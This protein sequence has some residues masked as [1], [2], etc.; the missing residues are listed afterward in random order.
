MKRSLTTLVA[1]ALTLALPAVGLSADPLPAD[2]VADEIAGPAVRF[3]NA[4]LADDLSTSWKLL[5]TGSRQQ[6][7]A[8][9]WDHAFR[10]RPTVRKPSTN[11][12][13]KAFANS[14]EPPE[15]RGVLLRPGEAL[16]EVGGTV[17]IT[18][19]LVLV[20]EGNAW[21]VDIEAS[22]ELNARG[23]AQSFLEAVRA[24]AG[25]TA[26]PSVRTPPASLPILK[27]L[28]A[29][30]VK[31]YR[32]LD[33]EIDGD[34]AS[35]TLAADIPVNLV[36]RTVRLGPGWMVDL[37]R[38]ALATD[39]TDPA[40]LQHA[41][42][43]ADEDACKEQFRQLSRALQMYLAASTDYF[44]DPDRWLDQIRPYLSDT[45]GHCPA[46]SQPG[47]SYA[48]NRNLAGM[49]RSEVAQP[50]RVPFLYES[51]LHTDN[52][53]DTG[54]S[55]ADPP[56]HPGGNLVLFVDGSVRS[57]PLR[58]SFQVRKAEPSARTAPRR[59]RPAP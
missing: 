1:L 59:P 6:I 34:R 9:E 20:R 10:A 33:A 41:A 11:T 27:A 14:Q 15:V 51:T 17:R 58:P 52:P 47:V 29:P 36:L 42:A 55:W 2:Q 26:P 54:E 4:L 25:M 22:D 53:A 48:M 12:L 45:E 7:D 24:E 44:P 37:S 50:N 57:Q 13:L 38:P 43:K 56:R 28:L 18:Q 8:V 46:D 21:L 5:S 23:A 32:L 16:V 19:Q 40:P 30:E 31:E 49:R 35:V 39:P 3:A